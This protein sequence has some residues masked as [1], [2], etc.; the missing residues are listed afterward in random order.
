MKSELEKELAW[1]RRS[2][3]SRAQ[4]LEALAKLY[5][6]KE[7]TGH[8]AHGRSRTTTSNRLADKE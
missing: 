1:M 8:D 7:E 6:Q 2:K 3:K 4:V 5:G